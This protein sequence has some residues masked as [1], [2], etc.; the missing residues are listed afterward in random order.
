MQE[1]EKAALKV[2]YICF[3][4]CR[5]NEGQDGCSAL[6]Y[7]DIEKYV[8]FDRLTLEDTGDYPPCPAYRRLEENV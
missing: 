7:D 1:Y 8:G 5:F 6:E 4:D 3:L 2:S